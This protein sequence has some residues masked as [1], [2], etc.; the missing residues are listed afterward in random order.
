MSSL[1]LLKAIEESRKQQPHGQ[2]RRC[3]ADQRWSPRMKPWKMLIG[4]CWTNKHGWFIADGSDGW[5]TWWTKISGV[6]LVNVVFLGC[7]KRTYEFYGP[8]LME[9]TPGSFLDVSMVIWRW[10]QCVFP[11]FDPKN[12]P[13]EKKNNTVW[14]FGHEKNR[15]QVFFGVYM[16]GSEGHHQTGGCVAKE[17]IPASLDALQ[18]R[19]HSAGRKWQVGVSLSDGW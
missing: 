12:Q 16:A 9:N 7:P 11:M 2:W 13:V 10:S 19:H 5:L 17:Q 15:Y 8:P 3:L 4:Q 14:L 18:E 1:S 6:C